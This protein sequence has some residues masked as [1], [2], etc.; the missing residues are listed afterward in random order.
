MEAFRFFSA[1]DCR[2]KLFAESF[3]AIDDA[4]RDENDELAARIART[5][6]LEKDAEERDIAKNGDL[7]EVATGI[8]REN[9]TDDCRMPVHDQQIG[10]SFA[11]QDGRIATGRGLVEVGF[12]S[13]D[14]D[15]HRDAA[16]AR[17]VRFD[18]E[19]KFGLLERRLH[20]LRADL[21]KRNQRTLADPCFAV[22]ERQD[23]RAR[24]DAQHAR[25]F[26][27]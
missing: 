24:D 27:S 5:A 7:I 14:L 11:L 1:K 15:V 2:E 6:A 8:A 25:R 9:A 22:V 26:G 21:C 13:V 4:R 12:V 19:L 20:T 23:A 10:F 18:Q 17:D 3:S 16:I